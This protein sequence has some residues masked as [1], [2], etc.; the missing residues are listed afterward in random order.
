[1]LLFMAT[2]TPDDIG[3]PKVL[4]ALAH[5]LRWRL[6]DVLS[7]D[8]AVTATRCSQQLGE[9]VA[10]CSYHLNILAKY[11]FVE[12][13]PGG[14]GREKPWRLSRLR[15]SWSDDGHDLAHSMAAGRA[16]EAFLEVE[17]ARLRMWQRRIGTEPEPWRH[18]T[19]ITGVTTFVTAAE[20][21]E[22]SER[23]E[24]VARTFAD[25]L[26]SRSTAPSG[27]RPVRIFVATSVA[28]QPAE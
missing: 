27:A 18:A 14:Q 19:G 26:D 6:I 12:E 5:P 17:F 22:L 9:S 2:A 13:A 1:M 11:G 8:G 23:L 15:H 3:D 10:S 20:L 7:I 16:I 24:G 21:R 4:R 25:R 28:E